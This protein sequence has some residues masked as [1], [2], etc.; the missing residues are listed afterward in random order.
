M[1]HTKKI[2]KKY[3]FLRVVSKY[4]VFSQRMSDRFA[5]QN[6]GNVSVEINSK[7]AKKCFPYNGH[8]SAIFTEMLFFE[9]DISG[10]LLCYSGSHLM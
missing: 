5:A 3:L 4:F 8:R 6:D 2:I 7:N 1:G 9:F 10:K